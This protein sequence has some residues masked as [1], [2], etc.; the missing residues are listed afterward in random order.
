MVQ[1][2][3]QESNNNFSSGIQNFG[4]HF[5]KI[6]SK[7]V[8]LSFLFCFFSLS[9]FNS[10]DVKGQTYTQSFNAAGIPVTFNY[11]TNTGGFIIINFVTPATNTPGINV[12]LRFGP[13]NGPH[14]FLNFS[15]PYPNYTSTTLPPAGS[16]VF[17]IAFAGGLF[18]DAPTFVLPITLTDFSTKKIGVKSALLTWKT[19]S[20]VNSEHFGIERSTDGLAWEQIRKQSA[21]GNSS[22][23]LSYS[24]VDENFPLN[25]NT[26]QVYYYRLKLTDLDGSF[27]YSDIRGI[28]LFKELS[29][30]SV[31]P[32]PTRDRINIDLSSID[33]QDGEVNLEIYN[34]LGSQM[35]NKKIT[36]SGI[37]W[38]D[39]G[40][41]P[42]ATYLIMVKQ[43]LNTIYRSSLSKVE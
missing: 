43:G 38:I 14:T 10:Q 5:Q 42:T 17:W 8:S 3:F 16:Y 11:S 41:L 26:S 23:E 9:L 37:E 36:G 12:Q 24:F 13:T 25:R 2:L 15:G 21:A 27:K 19:S 39:L 28:N 18:Q 35:M 1:T 40:D 22:T 29:T 33:T 34:S 32:N 20:E 7:I 6:K 30:I 31:Y 4:S